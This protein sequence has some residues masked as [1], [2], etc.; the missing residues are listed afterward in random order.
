MMDMKEKFFDDGN[1]SF[2]ISNTLEKNV[3]SEHSIE[4]PENKLKKC[5][6]YLSH[7]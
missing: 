3:Q 4:E 6:K 2:T 5:V 7:C 1:K